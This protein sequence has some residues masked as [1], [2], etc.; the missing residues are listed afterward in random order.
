R[1][2]LFYEKALPPPRLEHLTHDVATA[3]KL[4]LHVKLRYRRPIGIGFD[5]A[6]EFFVLEHVEAL[7]GNA[8]VIENLYELS[9]KAAHRELWR[10][11]HE[12]YDIVGLDLVINKLLDT[13]CVRP[14]WR[15][16]A[17]A[18]AGIRWHICSGIGAQSPPAS[19][20]PVLHAVGDAPQALQSS[21]ELNN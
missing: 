1:H 21:D 5:A 9:R 15:R 6:A 7:I 12:Q 19:F 14:S 8:Q 11:L 2:P 3:D 13:H 17:V 18:S 20:M 4:T 10:A 16:A